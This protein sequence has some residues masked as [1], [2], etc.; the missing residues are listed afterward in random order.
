MISLRCS[1]VWCG[2][3]TVVAHQ[4]LGDCPN[5]DDMIWMIGKIDDE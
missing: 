3:E 1:M 4:L 2:F 5:V